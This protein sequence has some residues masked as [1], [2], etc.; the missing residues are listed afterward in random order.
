MRAA[1]RGAVQFRR[2]Y[3]LE[4]RILSPTAEVRGIG[5]E[6]V[7]FLFVRDRTDGTAAYERRLAVRGEA[8]GRYD[9]DL[10][11]AGEPLGRRRITT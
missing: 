3:P 1:Q 6:R 11:H 4:L 2:V 7:E 5:F 8:E 10:R 9:C